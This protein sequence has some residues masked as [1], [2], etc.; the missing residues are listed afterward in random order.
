[1]IHD[2]A[3]V[4]GG[5]VGAALACAL[6]REGLR[7]ALV[8]ASA[9]TPPP[10]PGEPF[11]LRVSAINRASET[12]LR[13]LGAW[14]LL[15]RERLGAY[16][17]MHVWD[18]GGGSI[19]FDAAEVGAAELGFIVE[20]RVVQQ[21]LERC[22]EGLD[23]VRWHR[24]ARLADLRVGD[25]EVVLELDHERLRARLV[26]GADGTD[27]AVREIAAIPVSAARYGQRALV[28]N[29]STER[30]HAETAWQR[31]TADGPVAFLPL[32][33]GQSAVVWST[34]EDHAQA[35]L[36]MPP[37]AFAAALGDAFEQRL[38]AITRVGARAAFSLRRL[39]AEAYV[40]ERVALV[41][42]AAHTIHPLAGQGVNLGFLDAAALAQVLR[43][44]RARGRDLGRRHTLRRYE[45]WRKGHNLAMSQ[46]MEGFHRLFSND[47]PALRVLRN[48]GLALTDRAVPV[49]RE[50]IRRAM[51]LKPG[52][53]GELPSLARA[54][55]ERARVLGKETP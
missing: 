11:D 24:P 1:M 51:G 25:D 17:E 42:D 15:T 43:A 4:G 29:V 44:A 48:A 6:G 38:G 20:N 14:R 36:A 32:A 3:I 5:P 10:A 22:I 55:P 19:H 8:E 18:A 52:T 30:P 41:G 37:A 2:V 23:R 16:R 49:K 47:V 50:I 45:R 21:A 34:R 28:A 46:A 26:V 39:R 33:D 12:L 7:V 13:A 53:T 31:F 40:A 27:S 54:A 9:A 35:L